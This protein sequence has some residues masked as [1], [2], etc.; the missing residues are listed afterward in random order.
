MGDY[1]S[2]ES[3]RRT[4]GILAS[5]IIDADVESAILE[6]EKQVP[7][8]FNSVF[9][10]TERIDILDGDGTNRLLLDKN[11]VLSVRELK[12]DGNSEDTLNLEIYKE[13]GYIFLGES[14]TTSKFSTK[15][16][17]NVVKYIY[18]ILDYSTTSTKT[19]S[20]SVAGENI[21]LSVDSETDFSDD[22]WIEIYGMDGF[23]ETAQITGTGVG[24]I[25]V[26]KLIFPHESGSDLIKLEVNQNFKKLMNIITSIALVA[27]VVGESA[28]DTVGYDLGELHVQKGEP[29]TQWRETANQLI[30]ERNDMM[31]RISIRPRIQ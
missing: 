4:V 28:S 30:K 6:V 9:V 17:S 20:D 27:R 16:N 18:G 19:D 13:S 11:P 2:I 22:E 21:I 8:Y 14:S 31:N 29:Y 25:T 7:R 23:K 26:D 12:I 10:P 1:I 5:Q 24:Q 3:V 15:R